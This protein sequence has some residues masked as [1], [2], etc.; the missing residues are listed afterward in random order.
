MDNASESLVLYGSV[1]VKT[2]IKINDPFGWIFKEWC[3]SI[4]FTFGDNYE[5]NCFVLMHKWKVFVCEDYHDDDK[6]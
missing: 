3:W 1:C 5:I 4:E 2:V 6:K